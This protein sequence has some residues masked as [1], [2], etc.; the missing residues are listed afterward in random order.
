[1]HESIAKAFLK[2]HRRKVTVAFDNFITRPKPVTKTRAAF[3]KRTCEYIYGYPGLYVVY[4]T[5][6]GEK[7]DNCKGLICLVESS[8]GDAPGWILVR[9]VIR[10]R[11]YR[12]DAMPLGIRISDHVVERV[13]ARL[14]ISNPVEALPSLMMALMYLLQNKDSQDDEMVIYTQGGIVIAKP[15]DHTGECWCLVSFIDGDKV[16]PQQKI[17][18]IKRFDDAVHTSLAEANTLSEGLLRT[19]IKRLAPSRNVVTPH[20]LKGADFPGSLSSWV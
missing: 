2:G 3:I 5:E 20:F 18:A 7:K 8:T 19:E 14:N 1:M 6:F 10:A 12:V 15:D 16:R 17:E 9:V 13:M 11:D 4:E